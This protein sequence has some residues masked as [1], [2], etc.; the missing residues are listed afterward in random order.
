MRDPG[1]AGS[2]KGIAVNEEKIAGKKS[3]AQPA[4]D[5]GSL[6]Q[7]ACEADGTQVLR[8]I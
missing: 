7:L 1:A 8:Q 5:R 4:R 2:G 3:G 6:V